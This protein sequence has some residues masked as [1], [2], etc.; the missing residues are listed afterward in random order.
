MKKVL[1]I[2]AAV[3]V[4]AGCGSAQPVAAPTPSPAAPSTAVPSTPAASPSTPPA[5]LP[6]SL[7][8]EQDDHLVRLTD[9]GP[10]TVLPS[11]G[12]NAN[13]SPD[14]HAIAYVDHD[15]NVVV[16]DR[17]GQHPRTV[18]R[19]GVDAGFE[20]VWSPD[21][22]RVLTVRGSDSAP[23]VID[24][25]TGTFTPLAHKPDGIHYL[26][27]ADGRHLGYATGTCRLGVADIDGSNARLV[28]LI[29][30]VTAANPNQERSC[31]PYSLSPDGSKMAVDMHTGDMPDGDI[32]RNVFA[33]I[34]I[35]TRTGAT[36]RLP[37]SGTVSAVLF[38]PDG[39]ML[40]RTTGSGSNHLAL[41]S[42]TG[43]V[44]VQVTE[45][46]AAKEMSLIGYAPA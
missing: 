35:D 9:R 41:V 38:Q 12:I 1:V 2:I 46:A 23:G 29:G 18:L 24:V 11:G 30:E 45:P 36:V 3:L 15:A 40:V 37:V 33:N 42:A 10:V 5:G 27:S 19:G 21:S 28:P 32:G 17:D 34:V 22:T 20:P 39:G 14:G 16:V 26:W 13:V 31:D 6:G 44:V 4:S 8:Y 7:Y 25:A 43:A